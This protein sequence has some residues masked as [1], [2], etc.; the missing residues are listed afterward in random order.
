MRK[1]IDFEGLARAVCESLL[2]VDPDIVAIVQF[3]SSVYAP[4]VARDIDILVVTEG[5]GRG[6]EYELAVEGFPV[7]VDVIVQRAGEA[8][9]GP[10]GRGVKVS[11]RLLYGDGEVIERMVMD[12]P[13]PTFDEA[14]LMLLNADEYLRMAREETEPVR[15]DGHYRT[16]FNTLFDAARLAVM[17]YLGTEE[18]RW[19]SLRRRLPRAFSER[20]REITESLHVDFFY[21]SSYPSPPE[22]EFKRWRGVVEEFIDDLERESRGDVERNRPQS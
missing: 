8:L 4:E 7:G 3:G 18:T 14:R 5:E 22:E 21:R 6:E 17:A 16:A 15:K 10:L 11:G 12:V 1:R 20:F 2:A 19:G 9:S 13:V